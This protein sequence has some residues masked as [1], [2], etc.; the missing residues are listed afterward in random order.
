MKAKRILPLLLSVA[1]L[2][3]FT[4]C[5]NHGQIV[6]PGDV[7][8]QITTGSISTIDGPSDVNPDIANQ[9]ETVSIASNLKILS[10]DGE[11]LQLC[12]HHV[13][14]FY[15][16]IPLEGLTCLD[17]RGNSLDVDQ[18]T[19]NQAAILTFTGE[20]PQQELLDFA[21]RV[22]RYTYVFPADQIVSLQLTDTQAQEILSPLGNLQ[23]NQLAR[24]EVENQNLYPPSFTSLSSPHLEEVVTQLAGIRATIQPQPDLEADT[25]TPTILRLTYLDGSQVLVKIHNWTNFQLTLQTGEETEYYCVRSCYLDGV[26][27]TIHTALD[28]PA[29]RN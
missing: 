15:F 5:F 13:I 11:N 25:G 8:P 3:T 21:G 4:G 17:A 23:A 22:D 9:E 16:Q 19:A 24:L 6:S 29:W 27:N 20:L 26:R 1:L 18:L 28:Y 2:T 14:D 10:E 7:H 12:Q